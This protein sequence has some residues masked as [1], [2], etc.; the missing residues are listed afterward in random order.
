MKGQIKN[1][2]EFKVH[3]EKVAQ[4]AGKASVDGFFEYSCRQMAARFLERVIPDTP[5]EENEAIYYDI[6]AGTA[7]RRIKGGALRRGWVGSTVPGPEPSATEIMGHAESLK[8][9]KRGRLYQITVSNNVEYASYVEYGHRQNVG[10]YVPWLGEPDE[11]G[12]RHG[13]TLKRYKVDGQYF[14]TNAAN[15]LD[16]MADGLAAKFVKEYTGKAFKP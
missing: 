5:A 8:V 1:I 2:R 14:M 3:A 13:A 4:L 12:V 9:D 16:D 15:A 10:Q 7:V 11:N 6:G